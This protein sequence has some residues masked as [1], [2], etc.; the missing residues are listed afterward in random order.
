MM[1]SL[2]TTLISE[3]ATEDNLSATGSCLCNL[4]ILRCAGRYS[5][6]CCTALRNHAETVCGCMVCW[7]TASNPS[8]TLSRLTSSRS[9]EVKAATALTA[10][11]SR[12]L[13]RW[14]M[15]DTAEVCRGASMTA[16]VNVVVT[17]M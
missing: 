6:S 9:V 2:S 7:T 5:I 8:R 17:T 11:R 12:R 15:S 4:C 1:G 10:S 3:G 14:L 16:Q 13:K